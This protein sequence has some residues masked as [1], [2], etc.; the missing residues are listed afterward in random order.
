MGSDAREVPFD[1]AQGRLS[2]RLKN[3]CARVDA[4][5]ARLETFL[6]SL[7]DLVPFFLAYPG[8]TSGA[9]IY[10]PPGWG[11]MIRSARFVRKSRRRASGVEARVDL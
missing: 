10:R 2:L 3:G 9:L 1:F 4:V 8:L 11:V 7:R 5:S 6:P